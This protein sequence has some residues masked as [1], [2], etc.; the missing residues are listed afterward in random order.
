MLSSH[1]QHLSPFL[2][3]CPLSDQYLQPPPPPLP[4]PQQLRTKPSLRVH[5]PLL[6]Y[7]HQF[8]FIAPSPLHP[9]LGSPPL[10]WQP[11][12]RLTSPP[13][14]FLPHL[15]TLLP[16]PPHPPPIQYQ[17]PARILHHHR[18]HHHLL[19]VLTDFSPPVSPRA[20]SP[21]YGLNSE[22]RPPSHT[23]RTRCPIRRS[24]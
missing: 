11:N 16:F 2:C 13:L 7:K 18:H 12:A 23:P 8:I 10:L 21:R 22:L 17:P 5:F 9:P 6:Q 1:L 14:P 19:L 4:L 15:G 24:Y 20:R 3:V